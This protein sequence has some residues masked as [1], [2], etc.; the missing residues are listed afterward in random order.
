MSTAL[1][2]PTSSAHTLN[3]P[4]GF[5]AHTTSNTTIPI[6]GMINAHFHAELMPPLFIAVN[7][8]YYFHML[9]VQSSTSTNHKLASAIFQ[10]Q[11]EPGK[12][13]SCIKGTKCLYNV[14][15]H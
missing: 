13:Q 7:I 1:P 10:H 2:C 5:C 11:S 12:S 3:F 15:R 9:Y 8:T 14:Y 4:S 6:I